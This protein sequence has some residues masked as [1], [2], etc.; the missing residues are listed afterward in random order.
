MRRFFHTLSTF[1]QL[2]LLALLLIS[3]V[4]AAHAQ[5]FS[6]IYNFD[7]QSEGAHPLAGLSYDGKNFYGTTSAG[8]SGYGTVFELSPSGS[9]WAISQLHE[10]SSGNDGASPEA[11]VIIGPDKT[12][13]GTTASGGTSGFG[14]VFNVRPSGEVVLYSFLGG[15]DGA[16]PSSGDLIG[17]TAGN[18]YGTTSAGGASGN[19]TVFELVRSKQGKYTEKQLYSFGKGTDGSYPIGGVVF[20]KKGNLYGT[21]STGGEYGY[22]AIY[23]LKPS[24]SIWAE[25]ILYNFQDGNDGGTPYTGL[26]Q[27]KSGNFYGATVSGG[28]GAGGVVFELSPANGNFTYTV[29]YPIPGWSVSGSFRDLVLDANGNIFGTTHCDGEYGSGTAFKLAPANGTWNYTLLYQFTGGLD[30]L[31]IYSNLVV[32]KAGNLYGTASSGGGE[33]LGDIFEIAS[34]LAIK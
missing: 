21:T 22:G 28:T 25:S 24:G 27:D 32:D 3:T 2:S 26:I 8:G 23:E 31:Y 14:T 30:G 4:S 5:S 17:D 34:P 11:K 1:P 7:N 13:Y 15:N 18:I 20:D 9:G 33:G 10:F 12:L 16:Q 6:V 19:G 29:L